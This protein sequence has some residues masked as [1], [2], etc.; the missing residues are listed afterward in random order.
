MGGGTQ[1]GLTGAL[2]IAG[3]EEDKADLAGIDEVQAFASLCLD[4]VRV[5]PLK[6]LRPE[7]AD[8]HLSLAHLV[9]QR[10]DL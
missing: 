8:M 1:D 4:V 10:V 9:L 5:L 6:L 7:S 3:G 2:G